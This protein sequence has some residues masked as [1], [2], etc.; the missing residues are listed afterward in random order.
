MSRRLDLYGKVVVDHRRRQ[1]DRPGDGAGSGGTAGRSLRAARYRRRRVQPRAAARAWRRCDR[2]RRRRHGSRRARGGGSECRRELGG[3]DV[4]VANAGIGPRRRRSTPVTAP[5]SAGSSTSTST[6][7]GTRPGRERSEVAARARAH[8]RDFLDRRLRAD[9]RL[10]RLFGASKAAVEQLARSMRI[11]LAP[12]G[13]TVGVA[14]F[15]VIDTAMVD[16]FE[17]DRSLSRSRTHAPGRGLLAGKRRVGR[18]GA[19]ARHRTAAAANDPSRRAGG[20]PTRR[21]VCSVR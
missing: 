19:R 15:G 5:T 3:I 6:A 8:G 16:K 20:F 11:E 10:G 18:R 4:L 7:S 14:H 9:P 1:R 12:T 2:A 17:T 13:A 21:G